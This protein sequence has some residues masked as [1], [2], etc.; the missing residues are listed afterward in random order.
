ML[1]SLRDYNLG[2]FGDQWTK[3]FILEGKKTPPYYKGKASGETVNES[4][5]LQGGASKR[6]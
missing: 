5:R 1:E 6:K 3:Y 4:P 2:V